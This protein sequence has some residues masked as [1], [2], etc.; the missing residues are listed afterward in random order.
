MII[1]KSNM[2]DFI[3]KKYN[4]LIP[5]FLIVVLSVAVI[6]YTREYKSN[7]YVE[8]EDI[9]VYQYFSGVK[10][11][12]IASISRNKKD[13]ILDYLPKDYVVDLYIIPIYI[14]DADRVIFPKEMSIVFP[15]KSS[16][17]KLNSLT[18]LYKENN[19]YYLNLKDLNQFF[20]H[21][22]FYDGQDLYFFIDAV[23]IIV[24]DT[25]VELS[26]LSYL[27]CLHN[28]IIEYYDKESDTYGQ[29]NI[30]D[31]ALVTNDYMTIN[32]NTDRIIY[33]NDFLLL[34]NDFSVLK[35]I[36]EIEK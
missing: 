30:E 24:D 26:P 13:V 32:V 23:T 28:N 12:Y 36:T 25:K 8:T 35:K 10:M 15:I 3:K 9:E 33:N 6:L 29:I 20:D 4:L 34:T 21:A 19:L 22:F 18:E 11:E 2:L 31:S 17:Y 16:E 5:I 27:N 14:K 1:I 7:R